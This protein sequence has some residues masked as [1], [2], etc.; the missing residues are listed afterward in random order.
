[1]KKRPFFERLSAM[2]PRHGVVKV[3]IKRERLFE[4][5]TTP[6]VDTI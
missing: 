4:F 5:A 6:A 1:M 2:L 3:E